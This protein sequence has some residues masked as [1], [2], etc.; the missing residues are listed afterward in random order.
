M[1]APVQSPPKKPVH[2]SPRY[3][4]LTLRDAIERTRTIY[5]HDKRSP[6]KPEVVLNH[7]GIRL[8]T[9]AANRILSALKQY[10]LVEESDGRL[11][12]SEAGFRIVNMSEESPERR[13]LLR[14]AA[15]K[16]TII[17]DVLDAYPDG[18]PSDVNLGDFLLHEKNFNPDSVPFFVRV[19]RDNLSLAG[20]D[21]DGY[22]GFVQERQGEAAVQSSTPDQP[23]SRRAEL[24]APSGQEG[25]IQFNCSP[26]SG[27]S[28]AYRG[29][30]TKKTIH[31]LI[32]YLRLELE[33]LPD[34][35][36]PS[37]SAESP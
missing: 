32:G 6:A 26:S 28:L 10:G 27:V 14:E 23:P 36:E 30:V 11:R 9:G 4:G 33:D 7:L 17:Q 22:G 12:V 34:D 18:L 35:D 1:A 15:L 37:G 31:K 24:M 13:R 29:K 5:E 16:P 3:P 19:L 2:R 25:Q 20:F 8:G 21:E